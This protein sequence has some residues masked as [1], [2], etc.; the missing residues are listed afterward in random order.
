MPF[1]SEAQRRWMYA[2]KPEMAKEWQKKTPKGVKLP[3]KKPREKRAE[4]E[5]IDPALYAGGVYGALGA[6]MDASPTLAGGYFGKEYKDKRELLKQIKPGDI[7][8]SADELA[9]QQARGLGR[10]AF[11][12]GIGPV[13]GQPFY[14]GIMAGYTP[15][16]EAVRSGRIKNMS[17]ATIKKLKG[18]SRAGYE[19]LGNPGVQK[20]LM[21]FDRFKNER[22]VVYRPTYG[23]AK[24]DKAIQEIKKMIGMRYDTSGAVLKAAIDPVVPAGVRCF[25]GAGG[26]GSKS[27][28][29]CTNTPAIA[30][31]RAK[32][33][34]APGVAPEDVLPRHI[35]ESPN[36]RVVG[37]NLGTMSK[38]ERLAYNVLPKLVQAAKYG[39][40]GYGGY[41]LL[42]W[43]SSKMT[44]D[45]EGAR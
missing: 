28:T 35:S 10:K 21:N 15:Y 6:Y 3:K 27:K 34:I 13:T 5:G 39:L 23:A 7:L 26:I 8:L 11:F 30:A 17:A 4:E 32:G 22:L 37:H 16:E 31:S 40:V 38:T 44:D 36:L 41:T 19:Q 18:L 45:S 29:F 20:S 43:L 1:E 33:N 9:K 42:D 14:H 24:K 2:N 25:V 12:Y